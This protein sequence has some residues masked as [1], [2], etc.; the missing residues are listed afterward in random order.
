[1][2]YRV[3]TYNFDEDR[4]DEGLAWGES[5]RAT[6]E[7]IDGLLHVDG[8]VSAPGEGVIVAAYENEEA[9]NAV[10]ETV[11]SVFADMGQFMTSAPHTYS[12]TVVQ[13]FG[14]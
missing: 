11:M 1:M 2:F 13:S 14:R 5:V 3:T 8:F 9:F 4:Y 7:G 10:S 12:G 6:I